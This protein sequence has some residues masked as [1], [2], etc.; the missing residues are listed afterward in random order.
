MTKENLDITQLDKLDINELVELRSHY[1]N[2]VSAIQNVICR[3]IM[4]LR[5][6]QTSHSGENN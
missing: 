4:E 1:E 3:K 5:N 6:K 2:I